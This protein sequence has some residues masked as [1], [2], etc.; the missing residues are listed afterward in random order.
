MAGRTISGDDIDI[1][2]PEEIRQLPERHALVV[3]ENGK[4]IIAR[5]S[6]CIDGRAGARLLAQQHQARSRAGHPS[7]HG[8]R[9][10]R[11]DDRGPRRSPPARPHRPTA[12]PTDDRPH[13][14]RRR[15][16]VGRRVPEAGAARRN[17]YRELHI[18]GDGTAEQNVRPRRSA[19]PAPTLGPGQLHQPA[20]ART[21]SG[22]GSTQVVAWLNIEYVW[23]VADVIPACWPQHPHLVHEI[24]VLADQRR[25]AG[26]ALTSD[27]LE[28][29]HR[30]TLPAFTDRM[31]TR[32]KN[33]CDE[34]HQ[35][36]PAR[37]RHTRYHS[38]D[39]ASDRTTAFTGD[40]QTA[41]QQ[42]QLTRPR[43][44]LVDLDTGE[45][46]DDFA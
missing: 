16:A 7:L 44:A 33:H 15:Q 5:L 18:A 41:E 8:D 37:G 1:L 3:A 38:A 34:G 26:L 39:S 23:D 24:A 28:E 21:S 14:R 17:A 25:R 43:L 36:W 31:R 46:I 11:P 4:P 6:R 40:A 13:P 9:L 19:A 10:R 35:P 12:T 2:R 32:L 30:Y 22:P 27:A 29:W 45:I 42:R 20:A